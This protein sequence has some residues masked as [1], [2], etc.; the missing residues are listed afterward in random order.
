MH[1]HHKLSCASALFAVLLLTPVLA[2]QSPTA[3]LVLIHGHILSVDDKDSVAQAI[4]IRRGVIVKVGSDA[5]VME[6][7]G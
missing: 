3:D 2:A 7:A 5:E 4:A 6:F 1:L